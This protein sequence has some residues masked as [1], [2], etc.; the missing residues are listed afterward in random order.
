MPESDYLTD[1][2]PSHGSEMEVVSPR[3]VEQLDELSKAPAP[4]RPQ[5]KP[6]VRVGVVVVAMV[7]VGGALLAVLAMIATIAA[8]L[9]LGG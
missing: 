7:M 9:L 5:S 3:L 8:W 6:P 4:P 2:P 1:A